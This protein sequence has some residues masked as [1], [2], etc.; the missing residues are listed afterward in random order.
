MNYQYLLVDIQS[1]VGRITLNSEKTLNALNQVMAEELYDVLNQW[2]I[3]PKVSCIFLEGAGSRAFCAGGDIKNLYRALEGNPSQ[4]LNETCLKFF[5]TEYRLDYF[6]HTYPKPIITWNSGITMGGGMGLMNGASHRIVTPDATLAMPEVSIGLYPDV[7]ATWFY[8]K[9]PSGLAFFI[10][11]TG[12]RLNAQDALELGLADL[13]L[14]Q[15][16]KNEVLTALKTISWKETHD[17]NKNL[18]TNTLTKFSTPTG[19]SSFTKPYLKEFSRLDHLTSV[20]EFIEVSKD[21]TPSPWLEKSL[22]TFHKGSPSSAA[23]IIE[24]LKR[25]KQL[26]LREVF[27]FELKLSIHFSMKP[28]FKEGVRALLID[29][30]Q[31]PQWS[32]ATHQEVTGDWIESYFTPIT[33][34]KLFD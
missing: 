5:I 25:G 8:N 29:K 24:Q 33:D 13:C 7:G 18:I 28:D 15:D 16:H 20:K 22:E 11:L 1:G 21:F 32:P 26:S 4:E 2:K 27:E 10:S 31:N 23:V 3:D 12:A 17:E 9:L 30:D 6:I 14:S 34:I 19:I